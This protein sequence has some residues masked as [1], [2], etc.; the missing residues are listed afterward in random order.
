M[1]PS[2]RLGGSATGLRADR[3]VKV[4]ERCRILADGHSLI[5]LEQGVWLA[6]DCVVEADGQ[7]RIGAN[8]TVQRRTSII[9][10]VDIGTNCILAPNIFMSSGAHPI[11]RWPHL[12]IR[13]QERLMGERGEKPA[14]DPISIGDDCWLGVNVVVSPGVSIGQGAVVGANSVVTRDV[15][16]YSVVAGSPARQIGQRLVWS[17][18][19]SLD[20]TD[21]ESLPYVTGAETASDDSEKL[22]VLATTRTVLHVATGSP[23]DASILDVDVLEPTTIVLN[24]STITLSTSGRSHLALPQA[25]SDSAIRVQAPRSTVR[26]IAV[27]SVPDPT[28]ES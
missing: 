19:T 15:V 3:G 7:I 28:R 26:L 10:S 25:R 21:P 12:P 8:T 22:E 14:N 5:H 2:V 18:P 1:H 24:G 16:P 27:R 23:A 9:G 17:P 13:E 4:A 20:L 6:E 11:R